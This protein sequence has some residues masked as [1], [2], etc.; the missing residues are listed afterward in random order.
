M[1]DGIEAM[2][3][4]AADWDYH[5][6]SCDECLSQGNDLCYEGGYLAEEVAATQRAPR[7][8]VTLATLI[9]MLSLRRRAAL[10][11]VEA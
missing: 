7:A 8:P 2:E 5:V 9:P 3:V 6:E 11:G 1:S 4:A 10:P